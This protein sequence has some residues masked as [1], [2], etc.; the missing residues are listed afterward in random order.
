M[1]LDISTSSSLRFHIHHLSGRRRFPVRNDRHARVGQPTQREG[2]AIHVPHEVIHLLLHGLLGR[3]ELRTQQR[4]VLADVL[5]LRLVHGVQEH[6]EELQMGASPQRLCELLQQLLNAKRRQRA[7]HQRELL[8]WHRRHRLSDQG[9]LIELQRHRDRPRVVFLRDALPHTS[10]RHVLVQEERLKGKV[11]VEAVDQDTLVRRSCPLSAA[12][13]ARDRRNR[14]LGPG[15]LPSPQ[16]RRVRHHVKFVFG[17]VD[18]TLVDDVTLGIPPQPIQHSLHQS[19]VRDLK[20]LHEDPLAPLV[21]AGELALPTEE[22]AR[23]VCGEGNRREV[24][25]P[26]RIVPGD[27]VRAG[28]RAGPRVAL[29]LD[30]LLLGRIRDVPHVD[31]AGQAGAGEELPTRC[32]AQIEHICGM[33][34][35]LHETALVDVPQPS[36]AIPRA[37]RQHGFTG[38]I[39]ESQGSNGPLVTAQDVRELPSLQ[40]PDVELVRVQPACAD[41]FPARVHRHAEQLVLR[42]R[43]QRAEVSVAEE[44]VGAHRAVRAGAG[45][46]FTAIPD[47][48][49]RADAARVVAEGLEAEAR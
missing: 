35:G 46:G 15:V 42:R 16:R 6:E 7:T 29:H 17:V 4:V 22:E 36:G 19:I 26:K 34:E 37:G 47:K 38:P 13:G 23:A 8:V 1:L 10:F 24:R 20:L 25:V 48:G 14:G 32:E 40:R 27:A 5:A 2:V 30:D 44:V 39:A 45:D 9:I 49:H 41:D 28:H 12:W 18:R 3:A 31:R 43:N 33:L 21:D 11:L